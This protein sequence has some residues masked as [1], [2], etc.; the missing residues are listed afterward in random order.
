MDWNGGMDYVSLC[1]RCGSRNVEEG[2][3][4]VYRTIRK[5]QFDSGT[6]AGEGSA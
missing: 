2:V 1:S 5:R 4:I 3:L 6:G